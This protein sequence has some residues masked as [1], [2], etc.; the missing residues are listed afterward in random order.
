MA[1]GVNFGDVKTALGRPLETDPIRN[2]KFL[3]NINHRGIGFNLGFSSVQGLTATTEVI[4]YREGGF[5]TTVR[6]VPGQTSFAPVT[7]MRGVLL[8][9]NQDETWN[10]F[11]EIFKVNLPGEARSG[12]G[13]AR[14]ED[15]KKTF[16]ATKVRILVLEH[17]IT[18]SVESKAPVR[19]E[20]YNAWPTSISYSDLNAA[21]N[22]FLVEQ[23]TLVHEGFT[24]GRDV[25]L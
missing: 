6:Q 24:V 15:N 5:N 25:S 17:P 18:R 16:R 23:M 14:G 19:F 1:N 11:Q 2:F 20:L 13:R 7:F 10:W 9:A 4:P 21:D 22:A 12:V 3:V 8:G